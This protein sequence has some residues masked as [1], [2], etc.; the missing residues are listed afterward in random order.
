MDDSL[1]S[2]DYYT[3]PPTQSY[4]N[5]FALEVQCSNRENVADSS[6]EKFSVGGLFSQFQDLQ[7][8]LCRHVS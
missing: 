5:A 3:E 2:P 1:D 7:S 6:G 8:H 4:H